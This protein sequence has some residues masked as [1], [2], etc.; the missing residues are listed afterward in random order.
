VSVNR[1]AVLSASGGL[2]STSLL[3]NLLAEGFWPHLVS[4]RYGQKHA[5]ELDFLGRNIE[6]LRALGH[7]IEWR[8]VDLSDLAGMLRSSLIVGGSEVPEGYYEEPN[9]LSTVVPNRNAIFASIAYA[10]ALSL[11][12][13]ERATVRLG[14][15]V[16]SGDHAIY[17]D[18]RPE[19]FQK[20]IEALTLGNWGSERVE[21]YL[22]YLHLDK[23][24]ILRDAIQSCQ[25]LGLDF[26]QIFRNTL[27]SYAPDGEGRSGGLTGSDVERIL[28][29]DSIGRIDPLPYLKPWEVVVAQAKDLRQKFESV[30]SK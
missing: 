25:T 30:Q 20:L 6:A 22:P 5:L 13:Q 10:W 17:P 2:D 4:F 23:A 9:M 7:R 26:D 24:A 11:A 14:L 12:E 19:F 15:G 29:F 1:I 28:A 27:T 18:C 3:L 8:T 16:H 21:A